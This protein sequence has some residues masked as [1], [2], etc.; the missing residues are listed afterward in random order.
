MN[1]RWSTFPCS[2]GCMRPLPHHSVYTLLT[3]MKLQTNLVVVQRRL[4]TNAIGYLYE[5]FD[6]S[7]MLGHCYVRHLGEQTILEYRWLQKGVRKALGKYFVH[8]M[9]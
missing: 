6:I 3:A 8:G 5:E 9:T 2:E 1:G 7:R 4:G